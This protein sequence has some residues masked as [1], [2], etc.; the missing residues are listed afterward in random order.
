MYSLTLSSCASDWAAPHSPS[1]RMISNRERRERTRAYSATTKN[2]LIP[3]SS[4][5]YMS[6][7]PF[8]PGGLPRGSRRAARLGPLQSV[9]RARPLRPRYFAEDR[10][11]RSSRSLTRQRYQAR[12]SEGRDRTAVSGEPVDLLCEREVGVGEPA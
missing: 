4:A 11:R 5:A 1:S 9:R 8:T 10:R 3:T 6:L 7:R 12:W 2:A